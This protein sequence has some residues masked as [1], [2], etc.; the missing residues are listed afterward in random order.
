MGYNSRAV[1]PRTDINGARKTFLTYVLAKTIVQYRYAIVSFGRE[2]SPHS[3]PFRELV[4]AIVSIASDQTRFHSKPPLRCCQQQYGH[5]LHE[6]QSDH[7]YEIPSTPWDDDWGVGPPRVGD[8]DWVGNIWP[9][10]EFG[11][12]SH[13]PYQVPGASPSE[14]TYWIKDVLVSLAMVVDGR[15]IT[16]AV[17]Y[18]VYQSLASSSYGRTVRAPPADCKSISAGSQRWSTSSTWLRIAAWRLVRLSVSP[19]SC[20]TGSP[21]S[22]TTKRGRAA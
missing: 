6:C 1:V 16:N 13:L 22:S 5:D 4:F 21:I 11:S 8:D 2:W 18:C 20:T 12:M 9:L 10:L 19:R 14:T 3:F 7:M 17:E 15:A